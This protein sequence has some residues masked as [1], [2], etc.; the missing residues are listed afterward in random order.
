MHLWSICLAGLDV[1]FLYP[2]LDKKYFAIVFPE[3]GTEIID[4][5]LSVPGLEIRAKMCHPCHC[6]ES[7]E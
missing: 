3:N 4:R 5:E 2:L 1:V 7:H 6:V